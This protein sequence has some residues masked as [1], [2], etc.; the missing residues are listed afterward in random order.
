MNSGALGRFR[1]IRSISFQLFHYTLSTLDNDVCFVVREELYDRRVLQY[2]AA[3][4]GADRPQIIRWELRRRYTGLGA[5]GSGAF[6]KFRCYYTRSDASLLAPIIV[7]FLCTSLHFYISGVCCACT[8]S[9]CVRVSCS[10]GCAVDVLALLLAA[11]FELGI[12]RPS[13]DQ[14]SSGPRS[15]P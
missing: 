4:R 14:W 7:V 15:Y 1:C 9:L 10:A 2:T 6:E 11:K 8:G 5:S 13:S 12:G 3:L